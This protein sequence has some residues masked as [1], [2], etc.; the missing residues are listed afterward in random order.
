MVT[1]PQ[2]IG[3]D[4]GGRDSLNRIVFTPYVLAPNQNTNPQKI[5]LDT[6]ENILL[7]NKF[8]S[9]SKPN[10]FK[11]SQ[12]RPYVSSNTSD[13]TKPRYGLP[14][15]YIRK[16]Y[17]CNC[18]ADSVMAG[19]T[20]E[21]NKS[22]SSYNAFGLGSPRYGQPR[23]QPLYDACGGKPAPSTGPVLGGG[24][25]SGQFSAESLNSSQSFMS[26]FL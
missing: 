14:F 18:P 3:V 20:V 7:Y 26:E 10:F 9:K 25:V 21:M 4:I 23:S 13:I 6:I 5:I 1:P 24:M 8:Y 15:T 22:C 17:S 11:D 2:E 19:Q 12:G 16:T